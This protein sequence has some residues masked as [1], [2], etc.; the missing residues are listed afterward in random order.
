MTVELG[1]LG[2]V[3]LVRDGQPVELG[4][5]RQRVLFAL[6][7]MAA[8]Q[9]VARQ[10][11]VAEVWDGG[12]SNS[13][14]LYAMVSRLRR[15]VQP[16]RIVRDPTGFRLTGYDPEQVDLTRFRRLVEAAGTKPDKE[17]TL[18][19]TE[20]LAL[21]RGQALA[22]VVGVW[23]V[24]AAAQLEEEKARAQ[25]LLA[26]AERRLGRREGH[27]A[28]QG[29]TQVGEDRGS[30]ES[31]TRTRP[32]VVNNLPGSASFVV[33]ARVITGD[34][35]VIANPSPSTPAQ[36]PDAPAT[37]VARAQES[38]ELLDRLWPGGGT[39]ITVLTGMAGV[40]K[41]ALALHVA[42]VAQR[43]GWFTGGTLYHSFGTDSA[44][45]AVLHSFIRALGVPDEAVPEDDTARAALYRSLLARSDGRPVLVVLDDVG[46]VG[47]VR[48]LL[49]SSPMCT[50]LL[51]SRHR[52]TELD[53]A[54]RVVVAPL[55]RAE[56]VELL[57]AQLP[58]GSNHE[59]LALLADLAGRLPLA[60]AVVAA[61]LS[62]TGVSPQELARRLSIPQ[63]IDDRSISKVFAFAYDDLAPESARLL[64]LLALASPPTTSAEA[65]G[66][67]VDQSI[68]QA[69]HMLIDLA[70]RSL[71][72]FDHTTD[73][74][75]M[76]DLIRAFGRQLC[77]EQDDE[78]ARTAAVRKL[79]DHYLRQAR[80]ADLAVSPGQVPLPP[81]AEPL[82]WVETELVNLPVLVALADEHGLPD[83]VRDLVRAVYR[84]LAAL[85]R[86]DDL[87]TIYQSA[88]R[89]AQ[90]VGDR[91][92]EAMVLGNLANTNLEQSRLTD[93]VRG[94]KAALHLQREIGDR[95][96]EGTV[97]GNLGRAWHESGE[98][99]QAVKSHQQALALFRE[100][101][102]RVGEAAVLTNLGATYRALDRPTEA[103]E[104]L[105]QALAVQREVGD[106]VGEAAVLTN[107]GASYRDTGR[108]DEAAA[109]YRRALGI[110][111]QAGDTA[112][113]AGTLDD[114][115]A[116]L[117]L[118]AAD[119][120]AFST[121]RVALEVH[122][123]V[124]RDVRRDLD[125][126]VVD[127]AIAY[128]D[129]PSGRHGWQAVAAIAVHLELPAARLRDPGSG[130][131]EAV[132][133]LLYRLQEAAEDDDDL[134]IALDDWLTAAHKAS[135]S[136]V[137]NIVSSSSA[138]S[139]GQGRDFTGPSYW[140]REL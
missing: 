41:T 97:L 16:L 89:S 27:V 127:Q 6:L 2:P 120:D 95:H 66:A 4:S 124:V 28:V 59:D 77:L 102:D 23:A 61:H 101:G 140:R 130:G 84:P 111:R 128:L 108:L 13:N 69:R 46:S 106:R 20:A 47:Q 11:I 36:L 113:E 109:A 5:R 88:L 25:E 49:P 121:Y 90:R 51:T 40:G 58:A 57:A 70:R 60:L 112:A 125:A 133:E 18:L 43:R 56:A 74:C 76:H 75:S 38:R 35:H 92:A 132:I 99:R 44:T 9:P 100:V 129:T 29:G 26:E 96:G 45:G 15:T 134:A 137:V 7:L 123:D 34:V 24:D 21:W 104:P 94:Y 86:W 48:P 3:T 126:G 81:G 73:R 103:V 122:R 8:G 19:L 116:T 37:F 80:R 114:L 30:F 71:V 53:F 67:L 135:Q 42:H 91:T 117:R 83:R 115:G 55:N 85:G 87:V 14:V 65:A 98:Y 32:R 105:R 17:A 72:D 78:A 138:E 31:G 63:P 131:R 1:V 54:Q 50:V 52:L 118:M 22:D 64:R 33:Q 79:L 62:T 110:Y 107:L 12:P 68:P 10:R 136:G 39:P 82:R 93:A 139:A 119:E